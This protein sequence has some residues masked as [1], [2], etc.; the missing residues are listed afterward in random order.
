MVIDGH[1]HIAGDYA[2]ILRR[3]D[4]LGIGKTVLIGVGVRDLSLVTI[5]DSPVF[6]SHLLFRTLGMLKARRLVGSRA[7]REN[8]LRDPRNDDVLRAVRER[9]DRFAGFAF[10]NPE[11]PNALPE[12]KRCLEQGLR[13]IKLALVQ[14][15]TDLR[16]KN[17]TALCEVAREFAIPVFMHLG[18][19]SAASEAE[20]LAEAFSDVV[21]IIAHAGVQRFEETLVLAMRCDNVYV[22]TSSYIATVAKIRRLYTTLGAGKLIFGSDVPVMCRDEADALAKIDALHLPASEKRKILG[23]NLASV[24]AQAKH[25]AGL[26]R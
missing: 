15:P 3:M 17:M 18:I 2:P 6:R 4:A 16:G 26:A 21:F 20:W 5:H 23:G 22:D 7:F 14:Y 1:R 11:S 9:P 12:L 19:S 8:L 24:L 13:G 10:V 25:V